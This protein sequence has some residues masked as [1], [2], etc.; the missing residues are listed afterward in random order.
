VKR[1]TK[2]VHPLCNIKHA[3]LQPF[4]GTI[5]LKEPPIIGFGKFSERDAALI[6][7]PYQK[8]H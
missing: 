8:V 4:S 6:P 7:F 5:A 3:Y 2:R 1:E